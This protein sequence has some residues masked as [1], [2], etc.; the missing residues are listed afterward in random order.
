[1]TFIEKLKSINWKVRFKN[2]EFWRGLISATGMLIIA[3]LA[4]VGINASADI[5]ALQNSLYM[6][7]TGVFSMCNLL[8]VAVDPTT[9]G[10]A[11]SKNALTYTSPKNDYYYNPKE[12]VL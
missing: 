12:G 7:V 11:D 4:L 3:V 9:E 2:P 10:I 8:G 6:I 1:M 5:T